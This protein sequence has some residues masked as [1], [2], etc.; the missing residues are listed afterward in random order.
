MSLLARSCT[1]AAPTT[2]LPATIQPAPFCT[3]TWPAKAGQSR[4]KQSRSWQLDS[5]PPLQDT[6]V[7]CQGA[8]RDKPKTLRKMGLTSARTWSATAYR[9]KLLRSRGL[10]FRSTWLAPARSKLQMAHDPVCMRGCWRHNEHAC[11]LP[12]TWCAWRLRARHGQS[13]GPGGPAAIKPGQTSWA[14]R[15]AHYQQPVSWAA[16]TAQGTQCHVASLRPDPGLAQ[17]ALLR[18]CRELHVKGDIQ[19]RRPHQTFPPAA[20]YLT[21]RSSHLQR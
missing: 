12:G 7:G 9:L 11:L 3:L 2:L 16:R 13:L 5:S 21:P 6:L 10:P 18:P 15:S 19:L 20:Q 14:L 4:A 17:V 8:A 1:D